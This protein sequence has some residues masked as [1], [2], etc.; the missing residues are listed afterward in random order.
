MQEPRTIPGTEL[1]YT[2]GSK[3]QFLSH[4]R[5]RVATVASIYTTMDPVR[6]DGVAEGYLPSAD[7]NDNWQDPDES[8]FIWAYESDILAVQKY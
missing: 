3:V 6:W 4:G 2:E 7:L 8:D 5:T 1:T